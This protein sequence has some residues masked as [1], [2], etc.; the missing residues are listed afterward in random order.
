M[1]AQDAMPVQDA[2]SI[3]KASTALISVGQSDSGALKNEF[4]S[5]D[6][7]ADC[8]LGSVRRTTANSRFAAPIY[9]QTSNYYFW[10]IGTRLAVGDLDEL[11]AEEVGI[12]RPSAR[13]DHGQSAAED[14]QDARHPWVAS[15]R[16][17]DPQF[18]ER[19]H[20]SRYWSP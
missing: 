17:D 12:N 11:P 14:R 13:S 20:R 2:S 7:R 8:G 9:R 6:F 5:V 16:E 18:D 1:H 19:N 15:P 10:S 3:R 4:E